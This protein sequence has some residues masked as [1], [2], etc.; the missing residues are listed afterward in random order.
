MFIIIVV[1]F[2]VVVVVVVVVVFVFIYVVAVV[3]VVILEIF[4]YVFVLFLLKI[5]TVFALKISSVMYSCLPG[6]RNRARS[7]TPS[8]SQSKRL[9]FSL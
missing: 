1:A 7:H 3:V 2:V 4:F 9:Y 6:P 5:C 8:L